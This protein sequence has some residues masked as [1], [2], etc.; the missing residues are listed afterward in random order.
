MPCNAM[1]MSMGNIKQKPFPE[2]W[3]SPEAAKVREAVK[4]CD[5]NCWMIGSVSPA[6]KKSL[7]IPALWVIRNKIK[8]ALGKE[9]DIGL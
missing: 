6:M 9:A 1:E 7:K 2:I 4:Q 3:N 5:K 8:I